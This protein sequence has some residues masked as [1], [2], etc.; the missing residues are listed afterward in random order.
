[1]IC[2]FV[3]VCVYVLNEST[4]RCT[5]KT[6]LRAPSTRAL[7]LEFKSTHTEASLVIVGGR[8]EACVRIAADYPQ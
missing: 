2:I 7:L 1:M 8:F 4:T 6:P 5:Q 3:C